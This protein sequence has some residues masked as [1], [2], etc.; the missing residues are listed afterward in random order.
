MT[1]PE[2]PLDASSPSGGVTD[3]V[4]LGVSGPTTL[5]VDV[6]PHAAASNTTR[7]IHH[8]VMTISTAERNVGM[9]KPR[10]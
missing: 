5:S 10:T 8:R 1:V 7:V 3:T 6:D 9:G 2:P 4:H